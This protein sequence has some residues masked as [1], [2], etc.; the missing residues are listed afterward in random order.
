MTLLVGA[1]LASLTGV[2]FALH[3]AARSVR[4]GCCWIG[5]A[6]PLSL[7]DMPGLSV[8]KGQQKG[9]GKP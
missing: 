2:G 8:S 6:E 4:F 5:S 3:Q 7:L 9:P 1:S